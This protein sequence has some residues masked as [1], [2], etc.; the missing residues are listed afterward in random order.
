M[1]TADRKLTTVFSADVQGFSRLMEVDEEGTFATLKTYRDAMSRLIASHG[2]R[3]VNT[4]GDGVIAEF[5]SVVA[6]VRAAVDVQNELAT[7]N[8]GRPDG[9]RMFFRIGINLG[10][11]IVD[12][13]D[14]YGDG[15]NIA[16]RLQSEAQPGGILISNTVYDQVRNK[17][18]VG[19]EF[20]G[21]LSVKNI[22]EAIPSYAVRI[23]ETGAAPAHSGRGPVEAAY[24]VGSRQRGPGSVSREFVST[25]SSP[26]CW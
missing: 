13:T 16:A 3:V 19:F 6:A 26:P 23:G 18:P 20:L 9:T 11:V 17:M 5:P 25:G 4:W 21:N 24:R 12:G 7:H 2:G 8:A 1:D 22:D 14:I 15:V 10:D